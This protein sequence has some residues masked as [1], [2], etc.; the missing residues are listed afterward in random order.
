M[1]RVSILGAFAVSGCMAPANPPSLAPRAIEMRADVVEPVTSTPPAR[2]LDASLASRIAALLAE[3]SAGDADFAKTY[4]S[5]AAA[6]RAGRGASEGS[7]VWI[8]AQAAQS[9]LEIARQ[10]TAAALA[11]IDSLVVA[12]AEAASRDASKGGLAELQ[13][14][15]AVIEAMVNR[16][17]VRIEELTR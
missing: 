14:A 16:Q 10:R 5:S 8:G 13:A 6:M 4:A 7:E 3:A 1:F 15:Q 17:T 2:P 9:A 12:Q 11:E